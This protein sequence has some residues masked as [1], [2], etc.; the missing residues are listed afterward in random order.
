M[1][2]EGSELN[3]LQGAEKTIREFRPKLAIS[4]YHKEDDFIVIP[5]YLKKLNLQ[6]E[7]F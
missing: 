7:F 6:Y 5:D 2:I 3:A 1:D 4:L